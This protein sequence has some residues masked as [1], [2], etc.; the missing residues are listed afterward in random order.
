MSHSGRALPFLGTAATG[1][2]ATP[3]DHRA[4]SELIGLLALLLITLAASLLKGQ[5]S[6]SSSPAS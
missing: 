4:R 1:R 5:A 6:S 3:H 2:D